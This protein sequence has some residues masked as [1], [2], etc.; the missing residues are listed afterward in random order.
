MVDF[1]TK[2]I[3]NW[4]NKM[5]VKRFISLFHMNLKRIFLVKSLETKTA[6]KRPFS[7]VN[8]HMPAELRRL[9]EDLFALKASSVAEIARASTGRHLLDVQV[10]VFIFVLI[11][12]I[13]SD[14]SNIF[15]LNPVNVQEM[16]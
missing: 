16:R 1:Q 14:H 12:G 8:P 10:L 3:G 2:A 4:Q 6:S 11:F 13:L 15:N 7:G 5:N 9:Q